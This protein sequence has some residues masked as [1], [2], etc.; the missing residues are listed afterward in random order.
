[1]KLHS[2]TEEGKLLVKSCSLFFSQLFPKNDNEVS[3]KLI[4]INPQTI[5]NID[6]GPNDKWALIHKSWE[7]VTHVRCGSL[8]DDWRVIY[9]FGQQII[10]G[11][12]IFKSRID[13]S[14]YFYLVDKADIEAI[15][16]V[17]DLFFTFRIW[18]LIKDKTVCPHG[19]GIARSDQSFLFWGVSGAGK[20]T[21]SKISESLGYM[22]VHD[23]HVAISMLKN[24]KYCL[25]DVGFKT[26]RASLRAVFSLV[27]DKEDKLIA[28]SQKDIAFG[29]F[30]SLFET[31]GEK[32]L[33]GRYLADAF[34][35]CAGI[36]RVVPGYELHFTKSPNFWKVIEDELAI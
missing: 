26:P 12:R 36:A 13:E 15:S 22:I 1:M 33:F 21:V 27:Q 28:L 25:S 16:V 11:V 10:P 19:A 20:S 9:K 34:S 30:K 23:D 31:P 18:H 6:N 24:G 2:F 29:L 4:L 32:I 3:E 5:K 17:N 35:L 7:N 14:S 8:L